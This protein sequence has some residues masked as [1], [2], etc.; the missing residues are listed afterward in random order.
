LAGVVKYFVPLS[1]NGQIYKFL[2]L[3]P[4]AVDLLGHGLE[5]GNLRVRISYRSHVFS[6]SQKP[7]EAFVK[8]K[9]EQNNDR[10]FCLTRY[11]LSKKIPVMCKQMLEQNGKTWISQD[12]K[13]ASNLA[14]ID[15]QHTDGDHDV[16]FYSLF[17][18]KVDGLDVE[19][20]VKSAFNKYI[21][22]SNIERKYGVR[23][24]V[25]TCFFKNKSV[26]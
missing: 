23:Q 4:T 5:G 15:S 26:P 7:T 16:I 3:N 17:P 6:A 2:H 12:N 13:Q 21:K 20:V 19:M 18:S 11:K 9:D 10:Y 25:K 24:Q 14:V 22:F 1:I 8:L